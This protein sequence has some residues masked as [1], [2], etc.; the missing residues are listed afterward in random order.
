[1]DKSED[2]IEFITDR[3]GHDR[4]YAI[5]WSKIKNELDWQPSVKLEEGLKKT[6]EWYQQN[7]GWWMDVKEKNKKWFEEQYKKNE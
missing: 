6:V 7:K 2:M 1:M 5:D 3:P 4:R